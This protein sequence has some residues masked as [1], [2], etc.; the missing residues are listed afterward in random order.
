[1]GLRDCLTHHLTSVLHF[2]RE[3]N[4]T[5][6]VSF[7]IIAQFMVRYWNISKHRAKILL[8]DDTILFHLMSVIRNKPRLHFLT[9]RLSR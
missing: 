1:M 2:L 6:N 4:E 3:K 9:E 8:I 5:I 7:T